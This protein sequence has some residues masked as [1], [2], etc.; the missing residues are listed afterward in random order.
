V[1]SVVRKVEGKLEG[2]DLRFG[3]VVSRFNDAITVRLLEGALDCLIRHGVS[4]ENITV[5][6]V[7]GAFEIPVTLKKAAGKG[8]YDA[9]ISLACIIR[10]DTP[11]F[12]YV[13][14]EVAKGV[15]QVSLE[16][17]VPI[18]FGVVTADNLEQA[19]NRAGA[20]SGNKGFQAAMSAL[21]MANLFKQV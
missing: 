2:K 15:A 21:E 17:G 4:E 8:D 11:H 10:G 12:E 3:I 16:T 18:S 19:I 20:K 13:S 1:K 9:L 7:P 14:S 6:W 5:Y